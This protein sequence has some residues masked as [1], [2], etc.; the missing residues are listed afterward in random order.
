MAIS[1]VSSLLTCG[2]KQPSCAV[3]RAQHS[4]A[5]LSSNW[6][7]SKQPSCTHSHQPSPTQVPYR[8][9]YLSAHAFQGGEGN[10]CLHTALPSQPAPH[11][12]HC[13]ALL[14][15]PLAPSLLPE[16][17]RPWKSSVSLLASSLAASFQDTLSGR[18][19]GGVG[20]VPAGILY[21]HQPETLLCARC[22]VYLYTCCCYNQTSE[23]GQ[24][25]NTGGLLG[26]SSQFSRLKNMA[27][28]SAWLVEGIVTGADVAE[29]PQQD[30]KQRDSGARPAPFITTYYHRNQQE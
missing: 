12:G 26:H 14:H 17:Q 15:F 16:Q 28:A 11:A 23:G 8:K 2:K 24:R 7:T 21:I 30:R 3:P 29:L 20:V 19:N 27:L 4:R 18:I 5:A 9:G 13:P 22:Q 6:D 10:S 25:P 1:Y